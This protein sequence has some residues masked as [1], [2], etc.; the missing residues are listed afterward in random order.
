MRVGA[1]AYSFVACLRHLTIDHATLSRRSIDHTPITPLFFGRSVCFFH[2]L[3]A[4]FIFVEISVLFGRLWLP[5]IY[6]RIA[7]VFS[8]QY[9][10]Q[11]ILCHIRP[12]SSPSP[13]HSV[14]FCSVHTLPLCAFC[15]RLFRHTGIFVRHLLLPSDYWCT[16]FFLLAGLGLLHESA[17]SVYV[18]SPLGRETTFSF[19]SLL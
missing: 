16:S 2:L 6:P 17:V 1:G 4:K 3:H 5:S 10:Y 14:R 11:A 8:L 9:M 18:R 19:L 13:T 7:I 12:Y 15:S